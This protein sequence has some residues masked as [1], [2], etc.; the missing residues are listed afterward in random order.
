MEDRRI[1]YQVAVAV[2]VIDDF[3]DKVLSG[4]AVQVRVSGL[5][6]KPIRK[7]DGYFIFTAGKDEIRQIEVESPFYHKAVVKLEPGRLNPLHPVLKVR[8]QPNRLYG[9]PGS[10][11]LLEGKAEPGS[12]IQVIPETRFQQLKLLYDYE[13]EG[14]SEGREIRLFQAEKKDLAGKSLAICE[15]EQEE[16]EVFQVLEMTDQEQGVCILA[17][18]L[19]KGYKKAGTTIFPVYTTKA[20]AGG[21]Y[22]LLLPGLEGKEGCPCLVRTM[23]GKQKTVKIDLIPGQRNRLDLV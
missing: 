2:L 14:N 23:E 8:L 16:A 6:D 20:D 3:N 1:T 18:A 11:T 10:V 12:G 21:S 17:D 9:T 15:K 19:R 4:S 22:Y 13:R 5:P 7:T